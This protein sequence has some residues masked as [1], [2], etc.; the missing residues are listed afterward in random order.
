MS[1]GSISLTILPSMRVLSLHSWIT[2]N[3]MP[4]V[5]SLV[6][7]FK[8]VCRSFP[9]LYPSFVKL[10]ALSCWLCCWYFT[11]MW[12]SSA[13][14]WWLLLS[15]WFMSLFPFIP[16]ILRGWCGE[17]RVV[18]LQE[19]HVIYYGIVCSRLKW[20]LYR[21]SM[22]SIMESVMLPEMLSYDLAHML[23]WQKEVQWGYFT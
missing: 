11:L 19:C 2:P 22:V 5:W 9:F 23:K 10:H 6:S 13:T 1:L 4:Q 21:N 3:L 20:S 12:V 7:W 14:L 17:V 18:S 15:Q 16:E 8:L